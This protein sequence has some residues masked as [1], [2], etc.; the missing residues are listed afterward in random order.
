MLTSY[1]IGS[2]GFH[3]TGTVRPDSV[4][5]SR[6]A[7]PVPGAVSAPPEVPA[8]TSGTT[9]VSTATP[10]PDSATTE[11]IASGAIQR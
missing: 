8:T 1:W 10:R 6:K 3:L 2:H 9:S 4:R 11:T 5:V 7:Y